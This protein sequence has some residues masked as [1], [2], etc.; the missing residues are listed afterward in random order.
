MKTLAVKSLALSALLLIVAVVFSVPYTNATER[1]TQAAAC[2]AVDDAT[3]TAN[4][5]EKLN[6]TAA[7]A[8]QHIDVEAKSGVVTLTGTVSART[9]T[10]LAARVAKSVRCVKRVVNS[11]KIG[12]AIGVDTLC[13]C[14]GVCWHQTGRC[15]FCSGVRNC[16]AEYKAAIA[17]AAGNKELL[18]AAR[19]AFE[20]CKCTERVNR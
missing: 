20:K 18:A 16:V 13:C 7:L 5:Q 11:L 10:G 6:G 3:L 1:P 2:S 15:P 19:D 9:K 4:V 17:S 8:G 14:D 12:Q